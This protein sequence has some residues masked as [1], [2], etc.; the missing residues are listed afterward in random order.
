M[1]LEYNE[2]SKVISLF[3][4]TGVIELTGSEFENNSLEWKKIIA[5]QMK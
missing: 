1:R 2:E 3:H 5:A 4:Q